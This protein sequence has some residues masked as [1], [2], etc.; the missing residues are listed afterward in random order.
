M[1]NKNDANSN[2]LNIVTSGQ[3]DKV[4]QKKKASIKPKDKSSFTD[5]VN[6]APKGSNTSR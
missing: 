6:N 5:K 4:S 1:N 3:K 2:G